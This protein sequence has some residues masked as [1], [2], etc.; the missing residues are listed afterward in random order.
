VQKAPGAQV[1]QGGDG[2][3]WFLTRR[4]VLSIDPA[5]LHSSRIVPRPVLRA[6]RAGGREMAPCPAWRWMRA[7]W[8]WIFSSPPPA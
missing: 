5:R 2:R 8:R 3:V 4:N 7:P 1:A 6:I